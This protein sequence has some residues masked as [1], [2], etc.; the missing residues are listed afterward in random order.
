MLYNLQANDPSLMF[1]GYDTELKD[2]LM[3]KLVE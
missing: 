2:E 3:Q 1:K